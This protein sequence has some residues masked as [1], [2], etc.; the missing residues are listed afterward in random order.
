MTPEQRIK[1]EKDV[2]EQMGYQDEAERVAGQSDIEPTMVKPYNQIKKPSH[3]NLCGSD[4]MA[5]IEKILGTEG[6]LGFLCGNTWKYRIRMGKKQGVSV[7]QD[8]KK[9]MYYEK[10]Y[11][12]FVE[13]NTPSGGHNQS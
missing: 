11:N 10:L 1:F 3:Y 12:D 6:Y 9:A 5:T 7:E 8:L 13:K 2:L 4:T